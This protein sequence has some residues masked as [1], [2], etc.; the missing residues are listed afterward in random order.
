MLLLMREFGDEVQGKI[1]WPFSKEVFTSLCHINVKISAGEFVFQGLQGGAL[2]DLAFA[3][4]VC[5]CLQP[6]QP[7]AQ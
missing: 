4:N 1:Q 6:R 7:V 2:P 5:T 3:T